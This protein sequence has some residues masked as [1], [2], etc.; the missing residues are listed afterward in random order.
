MFLLYHPNFTHFFA[1][2]KEKS[3]FVLFLSDVYRKKL[4]KLKLE[5]AH[6]SGWLNFLSVFLAQIN[7]E[8]LSFFS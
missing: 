3:R 1:F 4:F 5:D 8:Q 6:V 7:F 2:R